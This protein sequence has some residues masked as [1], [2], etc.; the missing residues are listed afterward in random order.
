MTRTL[1]AGSTTTPEQIRLRKQA[2]RGINFN[3]LIAGEN[4]LGKKTFINSLC[5]RECYNLDKWQSN[6]QAGSKS[7]FSINT[8]LFEYSPEGCIPIKLRVFLTHNCG[9]SLKRNN[10]P[11]EIKEFIEKQYRTV[12]DEELKVNRN[13]NIDDTRIH[14]ALYFIHAAIKGLSTFDICMMKT[15]GERV[16]LIPVI[17]KSDGLTFSELYKVKEVVIKD[18]TEH[19]I[20]IFNFLEGDDE[21]KIIPELEST[22]YEYLSKLQKSI[23]FAIIGSNTVGTGKLT[24][25]N[26]AGTINIEDETLCDFKLVKNILFGSHLQEL[27][28]ITVQKLYEQFR[29]EE[30]SKG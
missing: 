14:V 17:A 28:D 15:I 9:F 23:P 3:I 22:E 26:K 27:K 8:D 16:N 1:T 6:S 10:T 2:K 19:K 5:D 20:K 25:T 24:R 13:P 11:D 18:I 30:L 29:I 12:L 21:A 7:D 4:D